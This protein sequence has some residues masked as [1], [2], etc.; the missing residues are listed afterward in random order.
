MSWG[1]SAHQ[2]HQLRVRLLLPPPPRH[3][4]PCHCAAAH[5][6]SMGQVSSPLAA[7]AAAWLLLLSLAACAS[8]LTVQEF[9]PFGPI[10]GDTTMAKCESCSTDLI[11]LPSAVPVFGLPSVRGVYINSN[12]GIHFRNRFSGN[13]PSDFPSQGDQ[14][15]ERFR[16]MVA[17]FWT[18]LDNVCLDCGETTY[19]T[20]DDV[21]VLAGISTDIG[22]AFPNK[23]LAIGFSATSAVI[24]TWNNTAHKKCAECM[25][26]PE[27]ETFQI[28]IAFNTD[29]TFF[30]LLYANTPTSQSTIMDSP[31]Q[32]GFNVGDGIRGYGLPGAFTD[33]VGNA[34]RR[35]SNIGQPGKWC[36][37]LSKNQTL[38]PVAYAGGPYTTVSC[39]G[40]IALRAN[41]GV[42][43]CGRQRTLVWD[44]DN[45]GKFN[46]SF[47]DAP[48]F[49][50]SLL[51]GVYTIKAKAISPSPC[52]GSSPTILSATVIVTSPV[53]IPTFQSV[54]ANTQTFNN[55]AYVGE[56]FQVDAYYYVNV[57]RAYNLTFSCGPGDVAFPKDNGYCQYSNPGAQRITA[58]LE[59]DGV[60]VSAPLEVTVYTVSIGG[61]YFIDPCSIV[62]LQARAGV[63]ACGNERVFEWDFDGDGAFD[64]ASGDTFSVYGVRLPPG[65]YPISVRASSSPSCPASPTQVRTTT[66]NINNA[67]PLIYRVKAVTLSGGPNALIG[68]SIRFT[69]SKLVRSCLPH[70]QTVDC[71]SD[72][73]DGSGAGVC[74]YN[75]AGVK[76]ITVT[77][78]QFGSVDSQTINITVAGSFVGGPYR[79]DICS[80]IHLSA[81]AGV[82]ACGQERSLAW[83]LDNN[84]VFDDAYG[85]QPTFNAVDQGLSLG[86]HAIKVRASSNSCPNSPPKVASTTVNVT[87]ARLAITAIQV[88]PESGLGV[89]SVAERVQVVVR[90]SSAKCVTDNLAIDCGAGSVGHEKGYC[91]YSSPG[92]K[93]ITAT[94]A[95]FGAVASLSRNIT[96]ATFY[97]GGPYRV[98]PCSSVRLVAAPVTVDACGRKR[99]LAWDFDNDG[100]FDDAVGSAPYLYTADVQLTPGIHP[101][102]V[103]SSSRPTCPASPAQVYTVNVTATAGVKPTIKGIHTFPD[104][105]HL[106]ASTGEDVQVNVVPMVYFCLPFTT[107]IDCG[108]DNVS[109]RT[110]YC[111]Y[112]T[113]GQKVI[114]ATVTQN[115]FSVSRT[116]KIKIIA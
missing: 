106:F 47:G 81:F 66:L 88:H 72:N 8:A 99:V 6:V 101:L 33:A 84:G 45:N 38:G 104:S 41:G 94:M 54:F 56:E 23:Q 18:P 91:R 96:I 78:E 4:P 77:L 76:F 31:A 116:L 3:C 15:G 32:A 73:V 113:P 64:D 114:T 25:V 108:A 12:G 97:M 98:A 60:V 14:P 87:T 50:T 34:T 43:A 102:R 70:T 29:T 40:L 11:P 24:V 44:F 55:E 1:A 7:M 13:I 30:F 39:E 59:Q 28:V 68:E 75:S 10:N 48:L 35:N 51:S 9:Y 111:Q 53:P 74:R 79:A 71:G 61:P 85:Q 82:D 2:L 103:R 36:F 21:N 42:D 67:P 22:E 65:A 16:S 89:A 90:S 19:R 100:V 20:I 86:V 109:N 95:Q 49:T 58:T 115:G 107:T 17:G 46:D 69:V 93:S 62:D 112:V 52:L 57:C 37:G 105:G 5:A 80:N 110:S 92:Q 83:D 63:D 26:A 27:R